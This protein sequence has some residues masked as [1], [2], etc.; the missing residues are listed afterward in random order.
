MRR[1]YIHMMDVEKY[2]PTKGCPSCKKVTRETVPSCIVATNIDACR[3]RMERLM[4]QDPVGADRV[5]RTK[6]RHDEAFA[7]RVEEHDVREKKIAR[8]S[9]DAQEMTSNRPFI[10]IIVKQWGKQS[11]H[12]CA[13]Q[14]GKNDGVHEQSEDMNNDDKEKTKSHGR[15]ESRHCQQEQRNRR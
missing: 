9:T 4:M 15:K 11:R 2:G 12:Q 8:R 1:M 10:I 14:A 6:T 5:V 13:A 3:E 7:R